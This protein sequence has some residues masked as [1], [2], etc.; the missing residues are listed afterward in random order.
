MMPTLPTGISIKQS[1]FS[2]VEL[3]VVI[4]VLAWSVR[5]L[6]P[7]CKPDEAAEKRNS[8]VSQER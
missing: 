8:A 4:V 2:L 1:G 6:Y 3:M 5:L 7:Y